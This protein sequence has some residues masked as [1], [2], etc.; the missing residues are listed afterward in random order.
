M[1]TL[2]RIVI[3]PLPI[4]AVT[5]CITRISYHTTVVPNGAS[6][7]F[8]ILKHCSPMGISRIVMHYKQP[9]STHARLPISPPKRSHKVQDAKKIPCKLYFNVY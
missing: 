4:S 9:T 1:Q 5:L 8:A 6:D 2:L 3:L 7:S